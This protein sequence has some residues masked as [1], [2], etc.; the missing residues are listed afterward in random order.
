MKLFQSIEKSLTMLGVHP[1][2]ENR[3]STFNS[4][5]TTVLCLVAMEALLVSCYLF[6]ATSVQEMLDCFYESTTDSANMIYFYSIISNTP[7]IFKLFRELNEF[8]QK[9]MSFVWSLWCRKNVFTLQFERNSPSI[10][11]SLTTVRGQPKELLNWSSEASHLNGENVI[12][13]TPPNTSI[14]N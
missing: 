2:K 14:F 4:K 7:G 13:L 9:S 12:S 8:T 11:H 3:N 1:P 5:N 6:D 10:D